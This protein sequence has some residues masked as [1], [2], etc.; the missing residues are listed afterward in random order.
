MLYAE[1]FALAEHVAACGW[2]TTFGVN[3]PLATDVMTFF[4]QAPN[5]DDDAISMIRFSMG[6]DDLSGFS[7]NEMINQVKPTCYNSL[8]DFSQLF[9]SG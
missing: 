9:T 7:M 2:V 4:T 3:C 1:A 6:T 5:C 8:N